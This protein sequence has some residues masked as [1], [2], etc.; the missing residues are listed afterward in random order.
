MI[1]LMQARSVAE[2]RCIYADK[3]R[4]AFLK[5]LNTGD[6]PILDSR[7]PDIPVGLKV[8]SRYQGIGYKPLMNSLC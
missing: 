6:D 1:L 4:R 3:S 8:R 2:L 5:A 7:D